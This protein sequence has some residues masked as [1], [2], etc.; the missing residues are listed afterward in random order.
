MIVLIID[1]TMSSF[2]DFFSWVKNKF[3]G[4]DN[5]PG[6]E[7]FYISI[8]YYFPLECIYILGD[9]DIKNF[10]NELQRDLKLSEI[11]TINQIDAVLLIFDLSEPES[12]YGLIKWIKFIR[13][14][15]LFTPIVLCGVNCGSKNLKREIQLTKSEILE[16]KRK[17][18]LTEYRKIKV[19]QKSFYGSFIKYP[20]VFD[21]IIIKNSRG[22][23]KVFYSV[24]FLDNLEYFPLKCD[25]YCRYQVY[26][27]IIKLCIDQKI[28]ENSSELQT[29]FTFL[30]YASKCP[31][32][33]SLNHLNS[34]LMFLKSKSIKSIQFSRQMISLIR[35]L[36]QQKDKSMIKFG[37]LCCNCYKKFF[38]NLIPD[39]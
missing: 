17:N 10:F 11:L 2:K 7:P 31:I 39:E 1:L 21:F 8:S 9:I 25:F 6:E 19:K 24:P 33:S 3:P 15:K 32:C 35:K 5:N 26:R 37:I 22:S 18:H 34:L 23:Y 12:L 14:I 20:I 13:Q 27:D 28:I 30:K 36:E 16:F 38:V 4:I 29:L